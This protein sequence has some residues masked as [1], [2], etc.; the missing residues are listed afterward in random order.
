MKKLKPYSRK[1]TAEY[2]EHDKL[3]EEL[4]REAWMLRLELIDLRKSEHA[5]WTYF[6]EML[7]RPDSGLM[8][9]RDSDNKLQ[10]FYSMAY[11]S[12]NHQGRK[13]LLVYSKYLYFRRAYR[14][15]S[16][17]LTSGLSL[18]P[19]ILKKYGF[20]HLY[21]TVSAYQQSYT[22]FNNM[23]ASSWALQDH[24]M[25]Q[26]ERH[27]LAQFAESI[28]QGDWDKEKQ[29][30]ANQ[31][32]PSTKVARKTEEVTLS[33]QCYETLNP[34]WNEGYSLFL[35][36]PLNHYSILKA[37]KLATRRLLRGFK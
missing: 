32:V 13:A 21:L 14:G 22:L 19:Y 17:I 11:F 29:L 25:P 2:V 12:V 33:H 9:A 5:D 1:L 23:M 7:S 18:L 4:L 34:R 10:G 31:S 26:W 15:N 16:T 27:V 6:S 20:R 35:M 8:L 3:T 24:H 36:A 37:L 28:F 30:I